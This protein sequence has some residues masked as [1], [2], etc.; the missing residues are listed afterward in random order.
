MDKIN[1][2]KRRYMSDGPE[3]D[4]PR[5]QELLAYGRAKGR[6]LGVASEGDV[7]RISDEYRAS[8]RA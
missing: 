5:W 4:R 1:S 7:E 2:A 6:E 8:K 3:V